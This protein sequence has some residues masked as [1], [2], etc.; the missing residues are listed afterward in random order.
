MSWRYQPVYIVERGEKYFGLIE[1][2]FDGAGKV[3][4]WTTD[5]ACPGGDDTDEMQRDLAHMMMDAYSWVP[6]PLDSLKPGQVLQA[7]VSMEDRKG[8]ADFIS[9]AGG[10]LGRLSKQPQT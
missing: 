3:Q 4:H 7:L 10:D 5:F 2:Y 6:V 8:L 9:A 1:V